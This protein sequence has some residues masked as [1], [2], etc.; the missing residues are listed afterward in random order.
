[1]VP[2]FRKGSSCVLSVHLKHLLAFWWRLFKTNLWTMH[3]GFLG[4]WGCQFWWLFSVLKWYG[5]KKE[6]RV[7]F[8]CF[9]CESAMYLLVLHFCGS[10]IVS[11][12]NLHHGSDEPRRADVI[13]WCLS[14]LNYTFC[15]WYFEQLLFVKDHFLVFSLS[16]KKEKDPCDSIHWSNMDILLQ[17]SP[18]AN[19]GTIP[20]MA[21]EQLY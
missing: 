13:C 17:C 8:S 19:T 5:Q 1:M 16:P 20:Q 4:A 9:H 18:R 10:A 11:F 21:T 14:F 2:E 6:K 3:I 15:L 12:N 7:I